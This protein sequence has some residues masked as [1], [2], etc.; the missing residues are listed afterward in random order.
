MTTWHIGTMGY[1]YK[2]WM[3]VFYPN[4]ARPS[5]YLQHY[6]KV[7][8]AVEMDTTFYGIPAPERVRAWANQT[9]EHFVFC[10]KTPRDITHESRIDSGIDRMHEFIEAVTHF[11]ERLGAILLQ[12]PPDFTTAKMEDLAVFLAA[13]PRNRQFAVEFRHKSWDNAEA[14]ELL[15]ENHVSWVS[16][17][18][19]I[20]PGALHV[21]T[22]F[23]Y[24]RFLGQHG[25][26][27]RKNRLQ[28]D[29]SAI[30]KRWWSDLLPEIDRLHTVYVFFNN[31]FSGHSPSTC[32]SFKEMVGLPV[33]EPDLPT[34]GRLF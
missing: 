11:G 29:V 12:F 14:R 34:Q 17:E 16:S 9:P 2:D 15:R 13:L 7:F 20:L 22:G 21:T 26:F 8:D 24:L 28:K 19:I 1:G 23:A 18:Y 33:K 32:N 30:L 10:P 31:D 4:H 5:N 3:G 25:Q 27:E 6:S